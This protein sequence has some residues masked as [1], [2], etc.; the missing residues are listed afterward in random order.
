MTSYKPCTMLEAELFLSSAQIA[1]NLNEHHGSFLEPA[2][3]AA[4][5][6]ANSYETY[7]DAQGATLWVLSR[8]TTVL[9]P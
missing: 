5:L 8:W 1:D 2:E 9:L 4:T 6:H 7:T 3:V